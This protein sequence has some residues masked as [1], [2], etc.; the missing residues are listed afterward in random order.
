MSTGN[1]RAFLD[2]WSIYSSQDTHLKALRECMER[3]RRAWLAL[4]PKKCRFMLPQGRLLG[5]IVCKEGLKTN[6]DKIKVIVE[7]KAPTNV[8]GVKSFLGHVGYYRRFIK[9]FAKVSPPLD[10]LTRK[11]EP[12]VWT[13]LESDAFEELKTRL[14]GAPILSYLNC[15][16]EF[17]VHVDASNYA[18]GATLAQEFTFTIVVRPGQSHVIAYQLSLIKSGEPLE[19]VND[20][21]PDAHLFRMAVL[22]LWYRNI[23][24]YLSSSRFSKDMPL[25]ERRKLVLR[26]RTFQLINGLLYKMGADQVLRHCVM[27]EE[28]PSVLREAHEGP[29]GGY[30]G[31]N[32]TTR[33]VLLVGLWWPMVYNDAREW[34]VGCDTYQRVDKPLKR[35]FMPLNPS[36]A[37]ELFEQ[38]GLDFVGPIKA[39]RAC[40]CCYIVV[41]TEYLTKWVEARALPDNSAVST[42]RFIYE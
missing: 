23:G 26:S 18:I 27:E 10:R 2:D 12:Y 31:P 5:H 11:G 13:K 41:A 20:D 14:L 1:F 8:T 21:F 7:M 34:V 30:M 32:T 38:W 16:K 33:K 35:D 42:T 9:N 25:G 4:N 36:H 6:P 17:H 39:S 19:G 40:R 24:E 22:P 3:C 15:D 37:Q 28:V 29:A